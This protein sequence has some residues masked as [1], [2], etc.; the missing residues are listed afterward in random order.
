[1][2][3]HHG[4]NAVPITMEWG[5]VSRTMLKNGG[6]LRSSIKR[7]RRSAHRSISAPWFP[8]CKTNPRSSGN[9]VISE[10]ELNRSIIEAGYSN[11]LRIH[12]AERR[13]NAGVQ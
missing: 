3:P 1:L 5:I 9:T 13:K 10:Y 4:N 7:T 12:R 8:P 2:T 6:V 11:I